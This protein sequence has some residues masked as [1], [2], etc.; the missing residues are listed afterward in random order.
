MLISKQLFFTTIIALAPLN[1]AFA[2]SE[3]KHDR[4]ID[5]GVILDGRYQDGERSFSEFEDGFGLGHTELSI[6]GNIDDKFRGVLTTVLEDHD[7]DIE[8]E[9]EEAFIEAVGLA[10]GLSLKAGRFLSEFGY[11]NPRHLH[12]DDFSDRPAVYRAY[13]GDH[14]FDDGIGATFVAPTDRFMSFTLEAFDGEDFAAP[15]TPDS[16]FDNVN[17][18]G[19]SINF[20]ADINESSSWQIGLSALKN[21][22]GMVTLSSLAEHEEHDEE[23]EDEHA[24]E[25]EEEH[26]HEDEDEHGH[27]EDDHGHSHSAAV[28]GE[29]VFGVDLTWKWAPNGNY[30]DKNLTLSAEYIRLDDLFDSTVGSVAGAPSSL[31][32]WYLSAAYQFAPQWTTGLRYGEVETYEGD[33]H[34][35]EGMLEGEY[36]V[37]KISEI[38]LSLAWHPSHFSTIRATYTREQTDGHDGTEDENIFVIQYIGSFGAHGAHS[39]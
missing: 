37:E 13:L 3:H 23:H 27:E 28:T 9:L 29:N 22:S 6:T 30:K 20:G 26:E 36:D 32:G 31:D 14:Y 15:D 24:H 2:E 38:D 25:E 17:V 11:L 8:V 39:F 12:E 4:Q 21:N 19:G 35:D 1:V 7:D 34:L 16:E 18:W 33:V 10:P 5:I